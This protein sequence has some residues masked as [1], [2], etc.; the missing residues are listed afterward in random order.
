M[1]GCKSTRTTV[2]TASAFSKYI[3]SGKITS[4]FENSNEEQNYKSQSLLKV[5][6]SLLH[7]PEQEPSVKA[8]TFLHDRVSKL[9]VTHM[10]YKTTEHNMKLIRKHNDII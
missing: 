7:L 2:Y 10:H 1:N 4:R 8:S 3:K 6:P 5:L 9:Q